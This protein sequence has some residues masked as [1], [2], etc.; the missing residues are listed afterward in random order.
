MPYNMTIGDTA[1]MFTYKGQWTELFGSGSDPYIDRYWGSS[2]HSSYTKGSQVSFSFNGTA[3]YAF[4]AKR[5]NHGHYTVT[6]DKG[7]AQRFDGYAPIQPDG[8]DGVFRVALFALAGLPNGL[9]TIVLTNDGGADADRP[10]LDFDY[11]TWTSNDPKPVDPYGTIDDV[12][13]S[14]ASPAA[15]WVTTRPYIETYYN[16]TLHATNVVGATASVTFESNAFSLWGGTSSDHGTFSVQVD[17]HDPVT[18]TGMAKYFHYKE[19]YADGLGPG[20]HTLVVTNTQNGSYLD[21]DFLKT[22]ESP[23]TVSGMPEQNPKGVALTPIVAGTVCGVVVGLACFIVALS[24]FITRRKKRNEAAGS[25]NLVNAELKPY[26][27][28]LGYGPASGGPG[29]VNVTSPA[30]LTTRGQSAWTNSA[31]SNSKSGTATHTPSVHPPNSAG[32][33]HGPGPY[34]GG[35]MHIS[36][37]A[38]TPLSAQRQLPSS[39]NQVSEPYAH[40]NGRA[41]LSNN[42]ERPAV[43]PSTSTRG[44]MTDDDLRESRMRVP[45]R[46]QDWGPVVETESEPVG[47]PPDYNQVNSTRFLFGDR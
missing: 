43:A 20:K 16:T 35:E 14:Y 19:Y 38:H 11:F 5:P 32:E 9:H 15:N 26:V 25:L 47:L 24:W 36:E 3:I 10:Y 8:A 18:L 7:P 31:Q 39:L 40:T 30:D 17:N 28:P 41:S 22:M 12:G 21:I 34:E 23:G 45:E 27:L 44:L 2:F 1:P 33:S 46:P 29:W 13:F 37:L 42:K 4:G 6:I